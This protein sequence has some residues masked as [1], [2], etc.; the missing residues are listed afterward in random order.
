VT[1]LVVAV[2]TYRRPEKLGRGLALVVEQVEVL[3]ADRPGTTA[4]VL[5]VDND[6]AA[7]A[8]DA[9]A[10]GA[11]RPVRYVCEPTPGIA[12]ARNR[13]LD[14]AAADDLL[15]FIDDDEWAEPGWLSSLVDTWAATGAAAVMGRVLSSFAQPVPPFVEAGR[16]F[17]RRRLPTGTPVPVVAAG[18]LLLD[19][20][21]V[22]AAGVR[23]D[24]SLGLGG[25]E[26]TLFSRR[27]AL[28]G[29]TMVWC[30]ESVAVDVVPADRLTREWVL[31]RAW[32][33]GLNTTRFDVLLAPGPRARR[34]AAVRGLVGGAV[35]VGGGAARWAWGTA[36]RDL[37]HRARG[38]R[39][40]HRGRGMVAGALGRR[41]EEYAR[42]GSA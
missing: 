8:R 20:R 25:G 4:A 36:A 11:G 29:R 17:V 34:V 19:L 10:A 38:L 23:F 31:R 40:L 13:A 37:T 33:H 42:V 18:N 26:D 24:E 30:D 14:E 32:S 28:A 35:R 2:L 7:S 15:V 5:V 22:R 3:T 6:P 21:Q 41:F 27:L 1:R 9:V 12:A 16:F 39:A